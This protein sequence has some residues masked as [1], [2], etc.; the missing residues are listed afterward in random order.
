MT[1]I[2]REGFPDIT[3]EDLQPIDGMKIE[4]KPGEMRERIGDGIINPRGISKATKTVIVG[5]QD[6]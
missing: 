3:D 6:D 1:V 4:I 2:K 5:D